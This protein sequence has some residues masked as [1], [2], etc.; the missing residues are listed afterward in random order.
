[1]TKS[2]DYSTMNWAK[3][4]NRGYELSLST[5]NV[6]TKDFRWVMDFN[7]A[8]NKSKINRLNVRDNSYEPS[9]EG[10]SV[11]AVFPDFVNVSPKNHLQIMGRYV[12]VVS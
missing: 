8:H 5:V 12:D 1:M 9:R 7:L 10:Y 4:T 3:L 2:G 11:G 6:K